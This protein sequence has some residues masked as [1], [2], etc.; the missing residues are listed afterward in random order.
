MTNTVL[1]RWIAVL[2]V[3]CGLSRRTLADRIGVPPATVER[4]ESDSESVPAEVLGALAEALHV[5]MEDLA[6][7]H[8]QATVRSESTSL[9]ARRRMSRAAVKVTLVDLVSTYPEVMPLFK[10]LKARIEP[11]TFKTM[12]TRVPRRNVEQLLAFLHFLAMGG[13][14][15]KITLADIG[16]NLLVVRETKRGKNRRKEYDGDRER[17][18]L[19]MPGDDWLIALI[20]Q[21]PV[22]VPGCPQVY[23]MDFLGLYVDSFGHRQWVDITIEDPS[24]TPGPHANCP[25]M[26]GLPRLKFGSKD[27][28]D[29]DFGV[30]LVANIH[31]YMTSDVAY[32][33]GCITMRIRQPR[34]LLAPR[35][36]P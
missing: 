36:K 31:R 33:G 5:P 20:P 28:L 3:D 13:G 23:T 6:A 22:T 2:R 34:R 15:H 9:A 32:Q 1:G 8:A 10:D 21:V 4:W 17:F 7:L 24:S 29:P 19:I 26:L 18:A 25:S 14:L 35:I 11:E 30:R 12:R 27:V 16:C